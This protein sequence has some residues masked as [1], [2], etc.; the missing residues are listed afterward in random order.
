[1]R[2]VLIAVPALLALSISVSTQD[3]PSDASDFGGGYDSLAPEQKALIDDW[4]NRFSA[5]IQKQVDARQAY[6]NLSLSTKTTFNAVTH[7]LLSTQLTGESGRKL[8]SAIQ[9]VAK[10]DTVRGEVPGTRGDEQF[11]IYVQLKPGALKLLDESQEFRR[12][13]DNSVYHKGYPICYRSKPSVPSI[14]V[15]ATRD[16]TRADVDVDYK[17]SGF[18]KALVN[19]HLSASNSDVRAGRNDEIHNGQWRGLNNWW[20][21]LLALPRETKKSEYAEA[22]RAAPTARAQGKTKPAEAVY[23]LLNTWLVE[24]KPEDVISY[25][26]PQ[27]SACAD[28]EAGEKQDR[29]MAPFRL[30]MAMQ[31]ANQRF[32]TVSRLGDIVTAVQPTNTG[33][34]AKL[35]QHRYQDQFALYEIREDAAEQFSCINR[36]DATGVSSKAAASKAFGKYYGAVFRVG[37]KDGGQATTLATLWMREGNGFWRLTSYDV[38][39]VWEEHLAPNTATSAPPAAPTVYA[40]APSDLIGDATKF[41][42]AWLVKQDLDEAS[43]FLSAKCAECLKLNR[44]PDEPE[45]KTAAEAQAGLRK[46]MQTILETTGKVKAL[47]QAIVAPLPNHEDIKLVKHAGSKAFALASIPDDMGAALDCASRTP[48]EP[49]RYKPSAGAKSYGNYYALGFRLAKTGEDSGVLWAVW[50]REGSEWKLT[51]YTVLTP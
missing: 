36:T 22:G 5:T 26:S 43:R 10:L 18:P 17:S 20:R 40:T 39:P 42:T 24:R 11:R 47:D 15:S 23:D 7:A 45:P 37:K 38:D 41:L 48:G 35:V 19:G 29:G 2:Q 14:Q 12:N 4:M 44:A 34:R 46:A 31:R 9:M 8:G 30:L 27:S 16:Q 13:D 49:V 25:F 51:A 21:N 6:D 1:M 3:T 28:L 50:A 32:G 33:E